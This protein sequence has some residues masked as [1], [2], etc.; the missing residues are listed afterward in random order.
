MLENVV[1]TWRVGLLKQRD[2]GFG[3]SAN[4]ESQVNKGGEAAYA[5][6]RTCIDR[7]VWEYTEHAP[8]V[9]ESLATGRSDGWRR[10]GWADLAGCAFLVEFVTEDFGTKQEV[11]AA[12]EAAL[13]PTTP[14]TSDTSSLPISLLQQGC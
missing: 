10:P 7:A 6:S 14:I 12:L 5:D 9:P 2:L 13:D 8:A 11:F 4:C 1:Q 3:F